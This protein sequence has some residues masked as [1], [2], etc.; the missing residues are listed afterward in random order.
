MTNYIVLE[1]KIS[2]LEKYLNIVKRYKRF[3]REQ[4][5]KDVD[6]KGMVERYLYLLVQST[7]DLAEAVLSFKNLR[8]PTTFSETFMILEEAKIIEKAL[9][10][11]MI[12]MVGFRNILAHDY[13]EINYDIVYDVLQNRVSDI[14]EF[15]KQI[16]ASLQFRV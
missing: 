15:N 2:S 13:A 14:E 8:K 3:S 16:K 9:A 1:N 12:K 11:K 10:E 6:I 4:I 5:E 7:I